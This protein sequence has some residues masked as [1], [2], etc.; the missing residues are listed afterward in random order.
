MREEKLGDKIFSTV[1]IVLPA[2]VLLLSLIPGFLPMYDKELGTY[3]GCNL[4]NPPESNV[5]TNLCPVILITCIYT[6]ILTICYFRSQALGTIKA[7]FVFSVTCLCASLLAFLPDQT[8][9]LMPF[10]LIPGT[11]AV[12]CIV[13]FIR[14]K[15]EIKRYDFD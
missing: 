7:I 5:M 1:L 8:V 3:V 10:V 4:L 15:L 6:L 9:T 2:L 14:M 13:A 11:W 12:M